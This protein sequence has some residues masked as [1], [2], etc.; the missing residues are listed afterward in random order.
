MDLHRW[1]TTARRGVAMTA[2][3]PVSLGIKSVRKEPATDRWRAATQQ[4]PGRGSGC[5]ELHVPLCDYQIY[6][7]PRQPSF[8]R[9]LRDTYQLRGCRT[10]LFR[11]TS[12]TPVP[13]GTC[14][15]VK[16]LLNEMQTPPPV[17]DGQVRATPNFRVGHN[18]PEPH[19]LH[20]PGLYSL[21][22]GG[23]IRI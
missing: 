8:F 19:V 2:A 3:N 4:G 11:P 20:F 7:Q 16:G 12:Q 21:R 14:A 18:R 13:R 22:Y 10:V 1:G 15:L 17:G 23:S 6:R 9:R 5:A